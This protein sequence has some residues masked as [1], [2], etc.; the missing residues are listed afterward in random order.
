MQKYDVILLS[1]IIIVK[2]EEKINKN[3]KNIEKIKGFD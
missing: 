1:I 3:A 2:N